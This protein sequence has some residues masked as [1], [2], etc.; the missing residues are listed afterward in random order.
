MLRHRTFHSFGYDLGLY[1]Q[2]FW[3]TLHG[4]PWESTISLGLPTPHSYFGDHFSPIYYAILPVY[5][6]FPHPETLLIVQAA[7]I[8]LGAIPIYLLARNIFPSAGLRLVWVL[9]YF[10]FLP[11]AHISLLD[12]HET[13]LAILPLGCALYF[14][15]RTRVGWFLFAL[16]ITFLIKEEMALI[17]V[18]FGLYILLNRRAPALGILVTMGSLASFLAILYAVIPAFNGGRGFAYFPSRYGDLGS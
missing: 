14:L 13:A 4:H 3:N 1:D 7:A 8:A 15:Q 10:L 12:F 16:L 9:L 11:L 18:G 17:G 5:A 2:I 6:L